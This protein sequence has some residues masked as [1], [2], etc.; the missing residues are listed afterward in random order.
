[1]IVTGAD[2]SSPRVLLETRCHGPSE[3]PGHQWV[4]SAHRVAVSAPDEDG[5][6]RWR[7]IDADTG[8]RWE[9]EGMLRSSDLGGRY[10]FPWEDV[11]V[12]EYEDFSNDGGTHLHPAWSPDGAHLVFSSAHPGPAQL[13][14]MDF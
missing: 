6:F 9:G 7:V 8:E 10:A 11:F 5:E 3:G 13:Y 2:E 14:R 1:M 4:G 12:A